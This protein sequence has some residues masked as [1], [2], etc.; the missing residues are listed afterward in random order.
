METILQ[1]GSAGWLTG[2]GTYMELTYMHKWTRL[3]HDVQF[4]PPTP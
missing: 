1:L 4:R 2:V 3:N